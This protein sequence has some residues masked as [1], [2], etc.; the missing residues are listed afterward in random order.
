MAGQM[1]KQPL[2]ERVRARLRDWSAE[3][4]H[5]KI[6]D[7]F[8]VDR[9]SVSKL[10]A[11][12]GTAITLDH[13]EGFAFLLQKSPAEMLVEPGSLLQPLS[14]IES[15]MLA[16][17]RKMEPH[18]QISLLTILQWRAPLV[19]HGRQKRPRAGRAELTAEQQQVADLYARSN[20][21]AQ[22]GALLI[23]REAAKHG[24]KERGLDR[25]IE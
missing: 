24:D 14:P 25:T 7:Y 19:P 20:V 18:E 9:S 8:H 5:Q 3:L 16:V 11:E 23:L 13:L 17:F 10:L 1:T 21:K 4:T 6:G 22:R 15:E 12:N 2:Q